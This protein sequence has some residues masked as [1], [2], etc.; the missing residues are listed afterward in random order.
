MKFIN[1]SEAG[2]PEVLKLEERETPSVS[3]GQVL[4]KVE[5]AGINRPDVFQRLGFY[6]PP[7][8]AS[9]I[10]GLEIS[11]EVVEKADD[12]SWP[13]VGDKVCAL[14]SG[15]GYAEFCNADAVLCLPIPEGF[16]S[17]QAAALPETFFTVWSNLF[18]RAQLVAGETVLIHGGSSGIGTCAI[19][20]AKAFGAKVFVTAGSDEKCQTCLGLGADL[21]INYKQQDYADV[22]KQATN[23]HGVDVILD[24]VAGDYINKNIDLAA[25]DGR[26][27]MI[28][29]LQGFKAEV[30]FQALMR[31]RV[32]LTGSTL[33][34]RSVEFKAEI[35]QNLQNKVWPLLASGQIKPVIHAVFPLAEAAKAHT[36]METSTH[37]G[38]IILSV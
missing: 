28:A 9:D 30:N 4:I 25:A 16:S 22:C 14:V 19:Q 5:A 1:I 29:A 20:M 12:V 21:A 6:P 37:I 24:M 2:A 36:L 10:P 11:G 26:I 3:Q 8:G 17:V 13:Q 15:G 31:N 32:T 33:R 35:A 18:D 34:P 27:V 7:P 23:G 38:K